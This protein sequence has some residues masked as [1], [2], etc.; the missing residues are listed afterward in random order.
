M[1]L[2]R[3][4]LVSC[5]GKVLLAGGYLVL[6]RAYTGIVVGTSAR[7]YSIIKSPPSLDP[8]QEL[9]PCSLFRLAI[10]SPQFRNANWSFLV[11][12]AP[13]ADLLIQPDSSSSPNTFVELAVRESLRL[14]LAL[15]SNHNPFILSTQNGT[16]V[17][18]MSHP[19][20]ITILGDND[21]YSQPRQENDNAPAIIK[22]FNRLN[23]SLKEV[24]KTGLGSS[25]AMVTSLCSAILIHFTPSLQP[26]SPSTQLLLHNLSQ[27]V[28]SLA[29]GKVGS[30][31]DVSAALY[32]TH[33][34]R[35]FSPA[36]L[37]GLLGSSAS[38][39]A[40]PT[41][42]Q[43]RRALDPEINSRW[44]DRSTAPVIQQFTIPKFTTL[45]LADVDAGSHTPSMV[46]QVLKWKNRECDSAD[47]LWNE[48]SVQNDQLKAAFK[49]L[50]QLSDS[51]ESNYLSQVLQ[52]SS[53]PNFYLQ[54]D[55]SPVS[56][57]DD[58]RRLFIKVSS[59]TK[60]IRRLMK[61]MGNESDVPIEPDSQ[62]LLLD[63]TEKRLGVIGSGVPGAGGYDAIWVLI[64]TPPS[65]PAHEE[66]VQTAGGLK[67]LEEFLRGWSHSSVRVLSA[68]SWV[69]GGCAESSG[70]RISDD[71]SLFDSLACF[72]D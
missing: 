49:R 58:V 15:Q 47:L 53:D 65:P 29:Q 50:E 13:N 63:E 69:I 2:S 26:Q 72:L 46:G 30:G 31:F 39:Q 27:Y 51:N 68:A 45:V 22:P 21:F 43:L 18:Q 48:L 64:F 8:S 28:H 54:N 1:K 52:L 66:Q 36:C 35:R 70:I 24:H 9:A 7:F 40:H 10:R 57:S 44:L 71:V 33:V 60:S 61:K 38:E 62:T 34:Y 41:P 32:G 19:I 3:E 20:T 55:P 59:I 6:D 56:D 23:T 17:D 16:L 42:D 12:P 14:S 25:A 67:S 11:S 37:D 5:P 4:T